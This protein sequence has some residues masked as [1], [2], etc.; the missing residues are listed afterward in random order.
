MNINTRGQAARTSSL[1]YAYVAP[2]IFD[3]DEIMRIMTTQWEYKVLTYKL[4]MKGF[5]YGHIESDLNEAGKAGW[6]AFNTLAPSFGAGQAIELA[7][8]LKKA[9]D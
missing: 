3:L 7:V 1:K 9:A 8:M 5:N 6:E 4:T 2:S